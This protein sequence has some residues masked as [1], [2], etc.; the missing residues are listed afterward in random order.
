MLVDIRLKTAIPNADKP[1]K[2]LKV[3]HQPGASVREGESLFEAEGGK[4]AVVVKAVISG[5]IRNIAAA[6]GDTVDADTVLATLEGQEA[7]EP[8]P[9]APAA[10]FDYFG[11]MVKTVK[12][13]LEGDIAIIG[14]GP[15]GYVAAIKAAQLG[16]RAVLIEKDA[17]GGTCLNRGCIP[18]KSLVRSAQVLNTLRRSGVFGVVAEGAAVDFKRVVERKEAV[19]GQLRDGI[20]QLLSHSG[21]TVVPG[22][23]ALA[24]DHTVVVKCADGETTV[25]ARNI[26]IATGSVPVRIPVPGAE[27]AEVL[28]SDQAL[29][30]EKLPRSMVIIGGGVI[31][32]E[33][34]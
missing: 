1:V 20:K 24:D 4:G 9:A 17:L 13:E 10:G 3:Y 15:G 21:V 8:A 33:F 30:L 18:T 26:I 32:M 28:T 23:A 14:G 11:V 7:V 25:R 31:G 34:A 5:V 22:V 19:V 27:L 6:A 2:I 16:A 12:R 29:R